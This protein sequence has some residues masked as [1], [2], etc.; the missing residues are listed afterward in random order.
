M[1]WESNKTR[2]VF[3]GFQHV[4]V[5]RTRPSQLYRMESG[6]EDSGALEFVRTKV[7]YIGVEQ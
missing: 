1:R 4:Y 3:L 2:G 7:V 6:T 5:V